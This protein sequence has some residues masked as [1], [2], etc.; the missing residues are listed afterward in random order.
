MKNVSEINGPVND[1]RFL[2]FRIGKSKP[3]CLANL[4]LRYTGL[5]NMYLDFIPVSG[6]CRHSTTIY[7][8]LP[9]YHNLV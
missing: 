9:E 1:G 3:R 8:L 2:S 7:I 5:G 6:Q 4:K